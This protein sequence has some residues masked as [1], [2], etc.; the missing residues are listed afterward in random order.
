MPRRGG[1]GNL[2]EI[3]LV[4]F[5]LAF[6]CPLVG[7]GIGIALRRRLPQHHLSSASTD[8]IKLGA[9][10]MATLV[11]LTLSLLISSANTY[12]SRIQT[13]YKQ[14]LADLIQLD[15]CLRAYGPEAGGV[16]QHIR[17]VLLRIFEERWPD[18]DFEPKEPLTGAEKRPIVDVQRQILALQPTDATQKWFQAQALQVS[19]GLA[20]LRLLM[21]SQEAGTLTEPLLPV[22]AL[23]F[24]ASIAIFGGFSLF[25][26]PNATVVVMLTLAALAIGGATFLIVELNA[27]FQG[28]LQISSRGAHAAW[29]MLAEP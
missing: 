2:V 6:L 7:A 21:L 1:K 9:G 25:V 12:R 27:P 11:A 16:R 5:A 8:V 20:H 10:L 29:Q 13:E 3:S 28:L 18:D 24:L 15:E 17:R 4:L 22:F 19:T 23:I 26:Q 14:V